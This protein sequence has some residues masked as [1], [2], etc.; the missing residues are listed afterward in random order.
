MMAEADFRTAFKALAGMT[1][2]EEGPFPWQWELYQRFLSDR[3]DNIPPSCNLPTGLGK[4]SVIHVWLLALA[5][6]PQKVPRRLVYVVNR[7]TVVDQTTNEVEG[8]RKRLPDAPGIESALWKLCS[9]RPE[10]PDPEK[11]RP[12]AISTLRGQFADN[13]EWSADPSRPAVICGTVDMIG[14][15]LLFSGYGCGFKTRPL[16]A[17]FLGQD[18]LIVHDEAHL[19]PAFQELLLAIEKEQ[20]R[21]K[22]F[23]PLKVMELTATSRAG[24]KAFE[25]TDADRAN[26]T[27]Q[28]RIGATKKLHLHPNTDDKPAED[29]ATR[30]LKYKDSGRAVLVFVRKVDDVDKVT[31]KLP[32]NTFEKLTG[33]LRGYERDRLVK[34]PIFQ[35]FLPESNR[36]DGVTPE[37]GTV[38]LVCTSAGEV[39]V[40]I[41]A[42]HLVCDLSTFESM[43]QRFGRV[44]RFG[45]RDDTEIHVVHPT[46]FETKDKPD[47]AARERTL[48]LL[49]TLPKYQD[50]AH[51]ASPAAL[52]NLDQA[53]R[54]AAF[55]PQPTILP[56]SDI[57]FD[58]WALTSAARP[59][60]KSELPGRPGVEPYLHGVE[61]EKKRETQVAWRAEVSLFNTSGVS[62]KQIGELLDD[63]P[64][65]P[66]ELLRDATHRVQDELAALAVGHGELPVW[67]I[68]PDDTVNVLTL[69]DLAEE[70]NKGYAVNLSAR[71]VVLPPAAGGLTQTGTLDGKAK[72]EAE[73]KYDVA[74]L[75]FPA[76]GVPLVRLLVSLNESE[77][78]YSL[79][80]PVRDLTGEFE[81]QLAKDAKRD[82]ETKAIRDECGEVGLK[83]MR[84]AFRLDLGDEDERTSGNVE[85]LILKA[86]Q[87]KKESKEPAAWPSV[88]SHNAGVEGHAGAIASRLNLPVEFAH[89]AT[90]AGLAGRWH[91]LGK[92]RAVWQRGAGNT[93]GCVAVAKT[94]HGRPPENL[95]NFRHELASLVDVSF[96]PAYSATFAEQSEDCRELLLHLIATH[97]GRG[98]PHFPAKE[99]D[100]PER[101]GAAAQAL[102]TAT[103]QRFARLQR[104]Y[105]RW[106]LAYL[107]SL[108]RAADALDSKRIEDTPIGPRVPGTWRSAPTL[109]AVPT[110]LTPA[111]AISVAVDPTNPGQFFACCGLLELADRLW[112]GAQGWFADGKFH[113]A[114]AGTLSALLSALVGAAPQRITQF[115]NGL[116]AKPIIAPVLLTF[117]NGMT[118][119]LDGWTTIGVSKLGPEKG[120]VAVLPNPPWNFWAGR[121][122]S[123][124]IWA[125]LRGELAKQL[126]RLTPEQLADLFSQRLFQG[127]RF[128]FD[129]GPAW[130]ALDVGFSPNEQNMQVES[131]PAVELLAAVGLQRFRPLMG[132]NR[133]SFTYATWGTPLTPEVA[134][135]VACGVVRFEPFTRYRGRV[136]TRGQYGALGY[137]TILTGDSDE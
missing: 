12:L 122:N 71:T 130:T 5:A 110:P 1:K 18:A 104:K 105:G 31:K 79:V 126:N 125:A 124:D 45:F 54:T 98:R 9:T 60:V 10:K 48:A 52:G 113:I 59:L 129:P 100:D 17:G 68:D 69:A 70:N 19:E 114:C 78:K 27:V 131:S 92:D 75:V 127:G 51:N 112:P 89:V 34:K 32:A 47:E 42:D 6:N 58:A 24:G 120:K 103:P 117:A 107:E 111:P 25:L 116:E 40:N 118:L 67:V 136:V 108:L 97:H 35:R 23:A 93:P 88:E 87:Q 56:T 128:G 123:H 44:N 90:A 43:A 33:T 29:I 121:M 134:R 73:R 4:T 106:G 95:N 61:D 83:P 53:E 13:R 2:P 81:F 37:P 76:S 77:K 30:A 46:K 28:Q 72:R 119:T 41:S 22:D 99:A 74:G 8:L 94:L 50:G 11:D 49:G 86:E 20:E 132:E 7:R 14:S 36:A 115:E 66:H 101:P 82:E 65:R 38:Y 21:C 102:V 91:D 133:D 39:G 63:F 64:L 57:L 15:R 16:H 135:A 85:Y 96:D 3:D 80:A 62:G 109:F 55:S 84:V 137:S 26:K